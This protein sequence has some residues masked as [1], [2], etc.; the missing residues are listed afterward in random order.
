MTNRCLADWLT[1]LETRHPCEIELGLERVSAV[2]QRYQKNHQT[3]YEHRKRPKIITVA[4]TNGKGSCI[5][6]MQ[7]LLLEHNY[8]VGVFTSPHFLH[9]NERICI[10]GLPVSD[11][12]IVSAFET[13]ESLRDEIDLTYFEFNT[14]AALIIFDANDL[15]FILLEV[16]LGGRLDATNIIDSDVAVLTS[17]D[18]DHQE[19]LGDTRSKIA[20]EKLGIARAG[21]PLVI[22]ETDYPDNFQQLVLDTSAVALWCGQE[23]DYQLQESTFSARLLVDT[24]AGSKQID[25]LPVQGLLPVNKIMALQALICAGISLDADKC[26]VAL[27][28]IAL[29][30]RQQQLCFQ[31]KNI[32][33]DV[34]HNP[35]AAALLAQNL[36]KKPGRKIAVASVLDDKDWSA[37]VTALMPVIDDWKIAELQGVSRASEGYSLVKLLYNRGLQATLFATV[38]KAFFEALA[39]ADSNDSIIVFGS[40]HTV[41][42]VMELISAEVTGE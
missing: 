20:A 19:W 10:S 1:L 33:L 11:A 41:A 26:R 6:S 39:S 34:A 23:F 12:E 30:G 13:I 27:G 38:K 16:G 18:L 31:G 5:A 25:N 7:A 22:G 15:D 17:I 37:M 32:I 24:D 2:W 40:F 14:L 35:A 9:Y 42:Q 4:G 3:C 21:K 8:S 28:G 36:T 29:S